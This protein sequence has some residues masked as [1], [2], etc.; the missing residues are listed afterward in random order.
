MK[1]AL[2]LLAVATVAPTLALTPEE[3]V[4]SAF[5]NLRMST[6]AWVRLE[7]EETVRNQQTTRV[8][9]LFWMQG[10]DRDGQLEIKVEIVEYADGSPVRRTV[11]DGR[12]L[13]D[14]DI[15]RNTYSATDY[16]GSGPEAHAGYASRALQGLARIQDNRSA[17]LVRLL[18]EVWGGAASRF[19]PWVLTEANNR[20]LVDGPA[21]MT[22]PMSPD[23]I[24][25]PKFGESVA[26]WWSPGS[27]GTA[28]RA[29]SFSMSVD[30]SGNRTLNGIHFRDRVSN[31]RTLTWTMTVQPS[32]LPASA[33]FVFVP[34][35]SAKPIVSNRPG[36]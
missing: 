27:N 3:A 7:S 17:A 28:R 12:I 29:I 34:P 16:R 8:H 24:I 35:A 9:D 30:D 31:D 13:W 26:V 20:A 32:V 14:Y 21:W 23:Q 1:L 10:F 4:Q 25:G 33:N 15:R 5:E 22:D 11:A 36:M 19:R 2:S 6:T 18:G